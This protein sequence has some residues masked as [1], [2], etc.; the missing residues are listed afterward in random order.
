MARAI[1]LLRRWDR[2]LA[3][4]SGAAALFEVWNSIELPTA[5]LRAALGS[6][7]AVDAIWPG[8]P[9]VILELLERPDRRLGRHP[10]R[11]RDRAL[12][13]SLERAIDRT[14]ALLGTRWSRWKWGALHVAEFEHPIAPAVDDA[15]ARRLS[16]GPV[17][18]GGGG[19]TVGDTGYA[20]DGPPEGEAAT[21][22]FF[23]VAS[24]ASFRQVVDVGSWDR[25]L[26]M[27]NPGQSGDPGSPHYRD[28]I[29]RWADGRP[30]PLLFSRK[31]VEA[32]TEQVISCSPAP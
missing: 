13:T 16:V 30:V 21:R 15:L 11:A 23:K 4:D 19:E 3:P 2:E 17:P 9:T 27:N 7:K 24:G 22:A 12:L 14:E 1:R 5:V 10:R 28:L 29:E 18:V 26:T 31:R 6:Q 25:S 32:A 8:D 20:T